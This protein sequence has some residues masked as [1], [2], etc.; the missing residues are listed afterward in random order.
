[1]VLVRLHA[2][3]DRHSAFIHH[4]LIHACIHIIVFISFTERKKRLPTYLCEVRDDVSARVAF[5]EEGAVV[6]LPHRARIAQ[7]LARTREKKG[8]FRR[9]LNSF[10]SWCDGG[11]D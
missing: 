10:R 5:A 8:R 4:E 11:I 3:L 1:M 2:C 7:H 9:G 6:P